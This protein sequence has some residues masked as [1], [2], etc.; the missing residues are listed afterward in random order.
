MDFNRNDLSLFLR[1][2]RVFM[3]RKI[4]LLLKK[5]EERRTISE[6]NNNQILQS[7]HFLTLITVG[8]I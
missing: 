3:E 1:S 2:C 8:G 7:E 6:Q 4:Y 5:K